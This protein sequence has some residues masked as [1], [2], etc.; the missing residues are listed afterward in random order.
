MKDALLA[1]GGGWHEFAAVNT[2]LFESYGYMVHD[3]L[4]GQMMS[5]LE[6]KGW[7]LVRDGRAQMRPGY[8]TARRL[9]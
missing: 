5:L 2:R 6:T 1:C 9:Q 8:E 4:L 3:K 7:I